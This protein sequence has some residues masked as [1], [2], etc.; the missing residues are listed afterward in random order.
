V[1]GHWR[2]LS[3]DKRG[4]GNVALVD[5]D[6]RPP[7]PRPSLAGLL[8]RLVIGSLL[9]VVLP[10][11][12]TNVTPRNLLE[13]APLLASG[14]VAL[15]GYRL[16]ALY[17]SVVPRLLDAMVWVFVYIFMGLV[18]LAQTIAHQL[19]L[20]TY[21]WYTDANFVRT[22]LLVW[23]GVL[24]Y[25]LGGALYVPSRR[26]ISDHVASRRIVWLLAPER[27]L[28]VAMI[29][30]V[31]SGFTVVRFGFDPFFD[32]RETARAVFQPQSEGVR[33]WMNDSHT[34]RTSFV[35]SL[36]GRLTRVPT[37]VALYALLYRRKRRP[38]SIRRPVWE[39]P[40]L[41][42]LL[43]SNVLVNNPF[44]SSRA[45]FAGIVIALASIYFPLSQPRP[46][47]VFLIAGVTSLLFVFPYADYYRRS[48]EREVQP[49]DARETLLVDGSFSA[50]QIATG[51]VIWVD[52]HG[53]TFGRHLIAAVFNFVPR[54]V[55]P[56]KPAD[57]GNEVGN[58]VEANLAAPLWTE[59][60]VDFGVAGVLIG[61]MACGLAAALVDHRFRHSRGEFERVS[62]PL[63]APQV[64]Y[65]LRGSLLPSLAT[66]EWLIFFMVL[67]FK[68]Y[69]CGAV[70][71]QQA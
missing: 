10:I 15:S 37:F 41:V 5:V 34:D 50:F 57:T 18:P 36:Y 64:W 48:G 53:H 47:R 28:L 4:H 46:F 67:C 2:E 6:R 39:N 24:G 11:V 65:I 14:L 42:L 19:P 22:L 56:S 12:F 3:S 9:F 68:R 63:V 62:T 26:Q 66:V 51:G 7:T 49:F 32:S 8:Q 58:A 16:V 1:E 69:R 13:P 33:S 29:G 54:A 40:T 17:G 55:W 44:S 60:Y 52:E 35:G 45:W 59:F 70:P 23:L 31:I 21:Y 71:E 25:L 30:L 38:A 27:I 20:S 43:V 61:F